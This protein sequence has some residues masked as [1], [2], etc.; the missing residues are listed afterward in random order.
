VSSVHAL[1]AITVAA[2]GCTNKRAADSLRER[3]AAV[4]AADIAHAKAAM[5]NDRTH[6]WKPA[7]Q[8]VPTASG[9]LS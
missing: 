8:T 6:P 9:R 2:R 4:A 3:L 1:P 5:R 7:R